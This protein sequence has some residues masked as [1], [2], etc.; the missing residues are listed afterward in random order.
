MVLGLGIGFVLGR[1]IP[2]GASGKVQQRLEDLQEQFSDYQHEVVT[3]F[4]TTA[5]LVKKLT[6]SYQDVQD[7]LNSS[8]NR[9]ALDEITRQRLI[10]A[11]K[12]EAPKGKRDTSVSTEAPKDYAPKDPQAPGA[13]SEHST[14]KQNA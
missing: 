10:A 4:N 11:L 9:L 5:S 14:A 7:H 2:G 6:K 12:S 1:F 8:A 3:H 13:L